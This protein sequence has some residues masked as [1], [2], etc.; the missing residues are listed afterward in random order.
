MDPMGF[1]W[2][3][4]EEMMLLMEEIQLFSW[5]V[6][7]TNSKHYREILGAKTRSGFS[8]KGECLPSLKTSQNYGSGFAPTKQEGK[9]WRFF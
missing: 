6:W 8:K 7:K 3:V 2:K 5:D 1:K 9:I 4:F